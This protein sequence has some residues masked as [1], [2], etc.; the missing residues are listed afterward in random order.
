MFWNLCWV[1][2]I[3]LDNDGNGVWWEFGVFLIILIYVCFDCQKSGNLEVALL[4]F[5][6]KKSVIVLEF[7]RSF[8]FLYEV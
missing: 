6:G 5:W 4:F 2:D 3:C 1:F 8:S 7:W